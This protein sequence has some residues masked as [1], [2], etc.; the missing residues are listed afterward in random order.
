MLKPRSRGVFEHPETE[1]CLVRFTDAYGV[2]ID[3]DIDIDDEAQGDEPS[4]EVRSWGDIQLFPYVED[5]LTK[6]FKDAGLARLGGAST[7]EGWTGLSIFQRCPYAWKKRYLDA[8]KE[9]IET[10]ALRIEPEARAVGTLIHTFLAIYYNRMIIPDYPLT[11]EIVRNE[12]LKAANPEFV[13]EGWRVFLAY[14]LYY[15]D[16]SIK[17]LAVEYD[18]VDPRSNKSCR[19]DLIA[20]F[21]D[22][23]NERLPGTYVVEHKSAG[24]FDDN[25][26]HGWANDGEVLGQVLLW[27]DLGLEKRFGPLR[28]V[29]VNLLGKQKE[30]KFHRE[31]VA[32]E[33]WQIDQHRRDIARTGYETRLAVL[34]NDFPRRRSGCIHRFGKCDFYDYCATNE[35]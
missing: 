16:E 3:I 24:R 2:S 26:L 35:G 11:P 5:V 20:F 23:Q 13:H 19:Y 1:D 12:L 8:R 27:K 25:T 9:G 32:P 15:S 33:T 18:L 22:I 34:N 10:E 29:I 31:T 28:G 6:I 4:L 30:P 17:P 21:D 14:T 7:G